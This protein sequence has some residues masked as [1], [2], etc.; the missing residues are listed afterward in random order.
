MKFLVYILAA[1]LLI[2]PGCSSKDG[3]TTTGNPKEDTSASGLAAQAVGGAL[4]SSSEDGLQAFYQSS[5]SRSV[6]DSQKLEQ[7]LSLVPQAEAAG[8]C[9]TFLSPSGTK[10]HADT[11]NST[12]YL[13]YNQCTFGS[14]RT[15]WTGYQALIMSAGTPACG[16]FPNPGAGGELI[17]RFV[18]NL[19]GTPVAGKMLIRSSYGTIGTIDHETANLGNFDGVTIT[20]AVGSGYGMKVGFNGSGARSSLVMQHRIAVAG[21]FDHSIDGSLTVSEASGS[22]TQRTVS[23]TV[24]VYLNRLQVIGTSTFTGVVHKNICCQPVGGT[25]ETT[26][27]AGA[28]V[29]P[30]TMGSLMVGKT[31]TLKFN[32]TCGEAELTKYDG[33]TETVELSRC[34]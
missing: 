20:A 27:S 21:V 16:T 26:F 19:T 34:F 23:G 33:T 11:A 4:S 30:T 13:R 3:G 9:P 5:P 17:R 1:F 24:T 31:E 15:T 25:I 12:L 8:L 28:N 6:A 32:G 18:K 7:I 14:G 2:L 22:A 10:C 29:T